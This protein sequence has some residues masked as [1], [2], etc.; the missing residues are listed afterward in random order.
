MRALLPAL[1]LLTFTACLTPPGEADAAVPEGSDVDAG[2]VDAGPADAGRP[3]WDGGSKAGACASVF[4]TGLTNSFGRLDGTITAVVRPSD[5][6][7]ALPNSDHLVVQLQVDGGIYR[8]V[9]NVKST[10]PDPDVRFRAVDA[11]LKAGAWQE[12]WHVGVSLDYPGDL[13]VHSDAGFRA[14][15]MNALVNEVTGQLELG[16]HLS[17]FS[18]SSGGTNASS[19]HL[20]HRNGGGRDGALVLNPDGPS[21]RYLLFHFP[22][23]TF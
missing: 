12:G 8:V 13:D 1:L 23:Q 2:P 22:E 10:G 7:C 6:G 15:P 19:S 5:T 17:A 9:V 14:V 4:G 21:P 18:S 20:V 3:G 11:A 16:T